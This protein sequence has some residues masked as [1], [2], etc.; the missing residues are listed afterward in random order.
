ML[1]WV[2]IDSPAPGLD[3]LAIFDTHCMLR[4]LEKEPQIYNSFSESLVGEAGL[5]TKFS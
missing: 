1:W 5:Q 3:Q 4:V 2:H